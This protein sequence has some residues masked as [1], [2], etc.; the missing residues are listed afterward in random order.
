MHYF[1]SMD[2]QQGMALMIVGVTAG[3]F[4]RAWLR[5]RKFRFDRDT[6]CGCAAAGKEEGQPSIVF[7]ARKGERPK[8]IVK[9]R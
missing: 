8:I 4:I 3:L 2:W 1:R 7:H 6:H 5:R 9:S